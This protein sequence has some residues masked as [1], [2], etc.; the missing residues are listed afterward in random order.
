MNDSTVHSI[1][2][3]DL[4]SSSGLP[5][6]S[7]HPA[8]IA[9]QSECSDLHRTH[10]HLK[11][12]TRASRK[13]TSAHDLKRYHNVATVSRDGLL[14][15]KRTEPFSPCTELII[16]PRTLL[17][18]FLTAMHLWLDHPSAHHLKQ[19]VDQKFY[20]LNMI[21]AAEEISENC[22]T[23][24]SLR[25]VPKPL[26]AQS[27]DD[28]P[29]GI[30]ITFAADVMCH[31]RQLIFALRETITS[32]TNTSLLNSATHES[33]RSALLCLC[34]ALRPLVRP[35]AVIC[36]DPAPGFVALQNDNVLAHH[37]ISLELGRVK[38]PNKNPVAECAVQELEQELLKTSQRGGFITAM[39]LANATARLNS[40]IRSRGLSSREMWTQRD[41]FSN[42]Q[43]LISDMTLI[44]AQH[45]AR[46]LNHPYSG[47][48]KAHKMDD[49][50]P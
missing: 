24:A 15:V 33:L 17:H 6:F 43:L 30:G 13:L 48:S 23:C 44:T 25:T 14:V 20:A 3:V 16:V 12:G 1:S 22:P 47:R 46:E 26:M 41:Q 36:V 35:H 19:L 32:Y 45:H 29:E 50:S 18:G 49:Q 4:L 40:P 27:S 21:D 34:L 37:G 7:N 2:V 8:W 31:N 10:A 38:N 28:P 11:Q 5:P 9:F 42:A 39:T